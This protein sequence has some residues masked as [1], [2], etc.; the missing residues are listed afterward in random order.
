MEGQ[1]C[2]PWFIGWDIT[3]PFLS[4]AAWCL[5]TWHWAAL[6]SC[7]TLA[8]VFVYTSASPSHVLFFSGCES[9]N[10]SLS[11]VMKSCYNIS[12]IFSVSISFIKRNK[13]GIFFIHD[14]I[15]YEWY[16]DTDSTCRL[17]SCFCLL[18][19]SVERTRPCDPLPLPSHSPACFSITSLFTLD[20]LNTHDPG[21]RQ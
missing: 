19:V 8:E 11:L 6:T 18:S 14:R 1:S 3:G 17:W 16:G 13:N 20:Y 2:G 5:V 10:V 7:S 15:Q 4:E 12:L 21:N 9:Q